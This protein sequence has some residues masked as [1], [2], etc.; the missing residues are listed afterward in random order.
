MVQNQL[1]IVVGSGINVREGPGI[2]F[3]KIGSLDKSVEVLEVCSQEGWSEI[4]TTHPALRNSHHGWVQS[5]FLKGHKNS[6][7]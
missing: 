6:G 2:Q 1:Y 7:A 4:K 5:K 3:A